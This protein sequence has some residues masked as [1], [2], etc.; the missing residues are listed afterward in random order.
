MHP[1]RRGAPLTEAFVRS[2]GALNAEAVVAGTR[3]ETERALR[4]IVG[5]RRPSFTVLAGL[6][7]EPEEAARAA[8]GDGL[9]VAERLAP[10]EAPGVISKADLAITWAAYGVAEEGAVVELACDDSLRL[11]SSLPVHHVV[12]L[13]AR[14]ILP[15]LE[16]GMVAVGRDVASA[17]RKPVATFIS[18]PSRTA[19][20]EGRLLYGAHGPHSLC[21]MV[22]GWI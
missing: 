8:V 9:A 21:V 2:L 16:D 20:I 15:R 10:D 12:L 14:K 19:D 6:P 3:E 11:A 1:K 22:L 4:E 17:A 5:R 7:P 18:G 13:S